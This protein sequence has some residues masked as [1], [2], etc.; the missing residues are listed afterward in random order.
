MSVVEHADKNI[1]THAS[2][3]S[4]TELPATEDYIIANQ[5]F[6]TLTTDLKTAIADHYPDYF[7]NGAR[8]TSQWDYA[9]IY[10]MAVRIDTSPKYQQ[11][12]K[13]AK[14]I[15]RFSSIQNCYSEP[16]Q[17]ENQQPRGFQIGAIGAG[18]RMFTLAEYYNVHTLAFDGMSLPQRDSFYR[19]IGEIRSSGKQLPA[20][21]GRLYIT[22]NGKE[23]SCWNITTLPGIKCCGARGHDP[24]QCPLN[25]D[26]FVQRET[27]EQS[28]VVA[29]I[30]QTSTSANKRSTTDAETIAML[31]AQL[32]LS[33]ANAPPATSTQVAP[34]SSSTA[35]NSDTNFPRD[36]MAVMDHIMAGNDEVQQITS[37]YTAQ[38]TK[39]GEHPP[40]E[41]QHSDNVAYIV[42]TAS[43]FNLCSLEW[44][45]S[46]RLEGAASRLLST[47]PGVAI[48]H[49]GN[50]GRTL[51][52]A[53]APLQEKN[54]GIPTHSPPSSPPSP[55]FLPVKFK[56][57]LDPCTFAL[58]WSVCCKRGVLRAIRKTSVGLPEVQNL[59]FRVPLSPVVMRKIQWTGNL[60]RTTSW[61]PLCGLKCRFATL[62][63][64]KSN[65]EG[66]CLPILG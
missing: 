7:Q 48:Q 9:T 10:D 23:R 13:R 14:Q 66:L 62:Q 41:V 29:P 42:D 38:C 47:T 37:R 18:A 26:V 39:D 1:R 6:A 45:E 4:S 12:L 25:K 30:E 22:K 21:D 8:P 54:M 51:G 61:N 63:G 19:K 49:C 40:I 58:Q 27:H 35:T 11:D 53:Q 46:R 60:R 64:H 43:E 28:H 32:A 15:A 20:I 33:A 52:W 5:F 44:L 55:F 17:L 2:S 3:M 59:H 65:Q 57:C 34:I 16:T 56:F 31:R 50:F 36:L 24:P